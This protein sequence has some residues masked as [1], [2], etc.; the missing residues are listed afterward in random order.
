MTGLPSSLI[1]PPPPPT[2]VPVVLWP[3][4][5][6]PPPLHFISL[7]SVGCSAAGD[8]YAR[9]ILT[10]SPTVLSPRYSP[11]A[12]YRVFTLTLPRLRITLVV[13]LV[14]RFCH[15]VPKTRLRYY[16]TEA[17][18]PVQGSHPGRCHY[19]QHGYHTVTDE[20]SQ[21][22]HTALFDSHGSDRPDRWS[23]DGCHD[24]RMAGTMT[25]AI[26]HITVV[27]SD[28]IADRL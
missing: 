27:V 17:K 12:P 24:G 7:T 20:I 1:Y 13:P 8:R 3:K 23:C 9:E 4:R 11:R 26:D 28:V 19:P 2:A 25:R 6:P 14:L 16:L 18:S 21:R 22:Y 15:R 10:T 5:P